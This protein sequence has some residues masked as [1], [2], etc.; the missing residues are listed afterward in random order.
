MQTRHEARMC[1][2]DFRVKGQGHS[3]LIS[4]NGSLR[5]TAFTW[6]M[7]IVQNKV[8]LNLFLFLEILISWKIVPAGGICPV[9]TDP[10]LVFAGGKFHENVVKTFH[11]GG[12]FHDTTPISF[13]KAYGFYFRMVVI[14]VKKTKARKTWKLPP[15]ENF[16]TDCL[17]VLHYHDIW[18]KSTRDNT[19]IK[20]IMIWCILELTV[21]ICISFNNIP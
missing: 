13:I 10:D 18:I 1:P 17:K 5:I 3:A 4:G 14:F 12:N 20:L 11:Y 15:H 19:C 16:Q 8:H 7:P 6:I 21:E 2:I 9:R